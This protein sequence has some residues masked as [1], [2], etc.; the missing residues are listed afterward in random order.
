MGK[1]T[2]EGAVPKGTKCRDCKKEITTEDKNVTKWKDG[3]WQCEDC[4]AKEFGIECYSRIVGYNS[5]KNRWNNGKREELKDRKMY[6]L[7]K[8]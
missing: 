3:T 8:N 5:P 1:F 4:Y 6:K 7:D 2:N